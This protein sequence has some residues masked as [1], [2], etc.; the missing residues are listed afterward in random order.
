M[1]ARFFYAER[2]YKTWPKL[3]VLTQDGILFSE[4]LDY[5]KPASISKQ[6]DFETF[7]SGDYQW[8]GYQSLIEISEEEALRKPLTRQINWISSYLNRKR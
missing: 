3:F 1:K 2:A 5:M 7:E 8:G 6:F 4:Y